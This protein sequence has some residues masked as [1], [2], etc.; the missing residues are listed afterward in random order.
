VVEGGPFSDCELVTGC[1]LAAAEEGYQCTRKCEQIYW[2]P[3]C[4]LQVAVSWRSS[5][6]THC[7]SAVYWQHSQSLSA[8]H[9]YEDLTV[10]AARTA[11]DRRALDCVTMGGL[12][13]PAKWQQD[14]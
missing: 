13:R 6:L 8:H 11:L 12:G 4:Q 1:L 10:Y 7:T 2:H 5:R 14:E 9:F 3:N